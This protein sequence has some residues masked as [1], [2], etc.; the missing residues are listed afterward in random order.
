MSTAAPPKHSPQDL[1]AALL[2]ILRRPLKEHMALSSFST[3]CFLAANPGEHRRSDI[4]NAI[5]RRTDTRN[6]KHVFERLERA[7][8]TT[9]RAVPGSGQGGK[10]ILHSITPEGLKFLGL[11]KP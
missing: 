6:V 5:L 1:A 8:L 10:M 7:G 2:R 9:S 3:L 11:A 4:M